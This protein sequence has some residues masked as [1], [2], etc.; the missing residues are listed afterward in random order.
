MNIG[1]DFTPALYDRGVSRYTTNL[2]RAL[3]E[4][5]VVNLTL[6][7]SSLRS[8]QTLQARAAKVIQSVAAV[9]QPVIHFQHLPP[10]VLTTLW[11]LGLNPLKSQ[12]PK[13]EVFHS[14]DWL[15]PP[16]KN[17]PL[18]STI[19]DVAMLKYPETAH[20]QILKAHQR[21]W[22]VLKKR[23]AEII[24][25]SQATKKD[26]VNLVG[27]PSFRIHVIPEALPREFRA[28]NE[29][30]TEEQ[31]EAIKQQLQLTRPYIL[32]VGTREPRKNLLRLIE[33]WQ[34]LHHDLDL[35]VVGA[36]GWDETESKKYRHV[37][38]LR[39]LGKVT[40]AQL[41]VLYA[42]AEAFAFPS[43][44]EGFG[45]PI[46]EAFYHGTPVVT[47]DITSLI[48]VAGNAAELVD[49]LSVEDIRRGLQTVL[50]ETTDQQRSRLQRMVIRLHMFSWHQVA[51]QTIEVYNQAIA[52]HA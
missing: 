30:L 29:A 18:V 52:H 41:N 45:L 3:L 15:Q 42:E 19:H 22:E 2:V 38:G 13:L 27:I 33:A 23:E 21:S 8:Y 40:D 9:N 24:A 17:L 31:T 1:I 26:I 16:D 12:L 10:S 36:K 51:E 47:S 7:G 14:W 6:Y 34:P 39:F 25:V 20:P 5:D 11:G 32:F 48:E 37:E 46:L 49:P 50:N 35:L 4:K 28:A 44:D 43:L